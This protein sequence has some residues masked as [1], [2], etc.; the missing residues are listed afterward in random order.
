ME[1]LEPGD[2]A[3]VGAYRLLGRLGA[4]GM[5]QVYLGV[6]RGGRKVAVKV[7][8]ADLVTDAEFRARFAREVAAARTVNGF[9]TAPVV[10]ADPGASPPWMVTAYVPGPSLAAAVAERGPLSE[11]EVRDLA[12]A[13]AE[14][15]AA[16]HAGGLVHR[17]LKPA[18]IILAD[19][20]PRIIDFGIARAAGTTTMT[21]AGTIIG[22]FT[23]MSPEQITGSSVGP[24]SDVFSLGSVLAFAATGRGPFDADTLPAITHRILS[25]PPDLTG[26]PGSLRDL[27]MGCLNK[28]QAKR[29]S[30]EELLTRLT[31]TA[32]S[33]EVPVPGHPATLLATP[34]ATPAPMPAPAYQPAPGYQPA[35]AY[36]SAPGPAPAP[37]LASQSAPFQAAQAPTP[38]PWAQASGTAA[39]P[40]YPS[41][42]PL[43]SVLLGTAGWNIT[44][45]AFSPDGRVLAGSSSQGASWRVFL[46]DTSTRQLAWAPIDGRGKAPPRMTFSPDGQL[47]ILRELMTA[48]LLSLT[49]RQF[50][51]LSAGGAPEQ[52]WKK[53]RFSPDGRMLATVSDVKRASGFTGAQIRL[54]DGGTLR[55][56]GSPIKVD[57]VADDSTLAFS[58]D[59]RYLLSGHE[60]QVFLGDV[61]AP[62]PILRKLKDLR[63]TSGRTS[64]SGDGRMLAVQS[65][66]GNA[67]CVLETASQTPVTTLNCDRELTR[68]EFCPAW[69]LLATAMVG[70]RK[71]AIDFWHLTASAAAQSW[72]MPFAGQYTAS[73]T[74]LNGFWLPVSDLRFSP[75]GAYFAAASRVRSQDKQAVVRI[76]AVS[77]TQ[78]G[79]PLSLPGPVRMTFSPDS[80][81]LAAS[82]HDQAVRLMSLRTASQVNVLY[83]SNATFSPSSQLLATA[84]PAGLRLWTLPQ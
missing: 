27:L 31:E 68:I 15:L 41:N 75:D 12:A 57:Y 72:P 20:G 18:N 69:P 30:L 10:D 14:G 42:P 59:S 11:P 17:D 32:T 19:D 2:P 81:F 5:G 43:P 80:R 26:L 76:W 83:G 16:I 54:W 62:Q 60:V 29:P 23:Y 3:Q 82:C 40:V 1:S 37:V 13:L 74:R 49:A 70:E 34:P 21:V 7:L 63:G 8:R 6:S 22:T 50:V 39:P 9:Y 25:Q 73:R 53:V 48:R 46:W 44:E 45:V 65:T 67:V 38:A 77:D 71:E 24:P 64:F 78:P 51:S 56:A 52:S 33:P 66:K 58:P 84:E 79:N 4:G 61:T 35:H 55:P 28:N 36:Q 47:L